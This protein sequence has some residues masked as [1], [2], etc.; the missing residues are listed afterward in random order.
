LSQGE[1]RQRSQEQSRGS[2]LVR[3]HA[4]KGSRAT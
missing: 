1:W 3:T 4:D 2:E